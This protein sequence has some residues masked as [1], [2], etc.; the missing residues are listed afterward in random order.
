[1]IRLLIGRPKFDRVKLEVRVAKDTPKLLKELALKH[2][3]QWGAEGNTG[4]LLDA[5][6]SGELTINS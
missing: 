3:F 4:K 6:A 1:M 2:G 5:I